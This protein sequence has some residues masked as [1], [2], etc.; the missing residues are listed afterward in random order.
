MV[1]DSHAWYHLVER[2]SVR[3]RDQRRA[4]VQTQLSCASHIERGRV[5]AIAEAR[6]PDRFERPRRQPS[7]AQREGEIAQFTL[8]ETEPFGGPL[9]RIGM[10]RRETTDL[11]RYGFGTT[12]ALIERR[13]EAGDVVPASEIAELYGRIQ[14]Q[15]RRCQSLGFAALLADH[16]PTRILGLAIL[17]DLAFR[18]I[19]E[20]LHGDSTR[21]RPYQSLAVFKPRIE[22]I[23]RKPPREQPAKHRSAAVD[24]HADFHHVADANVGDQ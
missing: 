18:R 21:V 17:H 13:Q 14:D 24:G 7:L 16:R 10:C 4:C 22:R 15:P 6:T 1:E 5:L 2:E 20:R 11:L 3:G 9:G 19:V 23:K 8:H 12:I